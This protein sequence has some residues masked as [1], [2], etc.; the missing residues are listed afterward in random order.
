MLV[1]VGGILSLTNKFTGQRYLGFQIIELGLPRSSAG[2]TVTPQST[3]S[4]PTKT[5]RFYMSFWVNYNDSDMTNMTLRNLYI[6][7]YI[8]LPFFFLGGGGGGGEVFFL[9]YCKE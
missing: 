4:W 6:D 5:R 3:G 8:Y 9:G 2:R 1:F 7:I